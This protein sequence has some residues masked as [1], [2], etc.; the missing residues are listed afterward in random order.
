MRRPILFVLF[1][2]GLLL[3]LAMASFAAMPGTKR[4]D[5]IQNLKG[6]SPAPAASTCAS[7]TA[8][9]GTIATVTPGTYTAI[10]Y[11]ATDG[12]STALSVKRKLNSNTAF[13]PGSSGTLVFN[14]NITS[15]KFDKY[16]TATATKAEVCYDL[17]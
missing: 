6:I 10:E 4:G 5:L 1:V 12:T 3:G 14:S 13:I 7:I 11:A 9:K 15:V 17:Q 2:I 8:T 16:S